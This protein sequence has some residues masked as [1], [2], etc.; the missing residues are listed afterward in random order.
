MK[1][2]SRTIRRFVSSCLILTTY[3]VG[4]FV[5]DSHT[6]RVL[7]PCCIADGGGG[8][9]WSD[10]TFF[11]QRAHIAFCIE[12]DKL[13]LAFLLLCSM[14]TVEQM[15]PDRVVGNCNRFC[16]SLTSRAVD[17][18]MRLIRQF[19]STIAAGL[20]RLFAESASCCWQLVYFF[21]PTPCWRDIRYRQSQSPPAF[22]RVV[23]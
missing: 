9:R 4:E 13:E 19:L 8:A 22:P 20:P 23:A 1:H 14:H 21:Q 7:D 3:M 6:R 15:S 10:S 18:T 12:R 16:H 5:D 11:P 17:V 2:S